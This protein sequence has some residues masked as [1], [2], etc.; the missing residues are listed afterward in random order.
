M[1][2]TQFRNRR[3]AFV[4][5]DI[6]QGDLAAVGNQVLGHGKAETGDAAGDHGA[7]VGE[8][9]GESLRAETRDFSGCAAQ[10]R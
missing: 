8:L 9:H 1:L 3:C 4:R 2:G 7:D 5:I 6:E 10:E